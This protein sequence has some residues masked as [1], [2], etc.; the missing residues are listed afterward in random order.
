[1]SSTKYFVN[2]CN[3]S[4]STLL[5]EI[6]KNIVSNEGNCFYDSENVKKHSEQYLNLISILDRQ[7]KISKNHSSAQGSS[8]FNGLDYY[9]AC[10]NE[11]IY[12]AHFPIKRFLFDSVHRTYSKLDA[13]II[14]TAKEYQSLIFCPIRNPLDIIVSNAF[15]LENLLLWMYPGDINNKTFSDVRLNHGTTLLKNLEW[16]DNIASLVKQYNLAHL[17]YKDETHWIK[18]EEIIDNPLENI[19]K[20]GNIAG[21]NIDKKIATRIWEKVGFKPLTKWKTHYF[22]PGQG[23]W[24][25]YLSHEHL[26]ILIN[27][28]WQTIL[29]NLGYRIDL[30][31]CLFEEDVV[32]MDEIKSKDNI[33]NYVAI[34]DACFSLQFGKSIQFQR[35]N[36]RIL[37]TEIGGHVINCATNSDNFANLFETMP[38]EELLDNFAY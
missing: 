27:E 29:D 21:V 13:N 17:R 24:K 20:I 12:L 23:K 36:I 38:S 10:K 16:F 11:F 28:D 4:G 32:N 14:N 19:I 2:G 30:E 34:R 26:R 6:L 22:K 33:Y 7:F 9:C 8:Q 1:M 25:N 37:K 18:Y 5:F 31:S 3:R 35:D 15:E